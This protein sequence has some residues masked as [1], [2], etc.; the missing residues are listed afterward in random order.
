MRLQN[1]KNAI[2]GRP[3]SNNQLAR[4]KLNVLWGLPVLASDAVSSVAYA[5]EEIMI[6]LVAGVA[7]GLN[8][9][10]YAPFVAIPIIVLLVTLV[11]SY[12]QIINHYPNGGG[13]Y[14]V[15]SDNFGKKAGLLAGTA[16]IVDYIM[17]VAVSVSA[18]TQA[19]IAAFGFMAPYRTPFSI[20][21]I[22]LVSVLNLRGIRESSRIFG[23]PTYIFIFSMGLMIVVGF[24]R[25]ITG[26]LTPIDPA[27]YANTVHSVSNDIF[28][29]IYL[30]AFASGC[31]A[32]TGVEAVSNAI[33]N[34][35][36]PAQKRAKRVL[37]LLGITIVFIMSG[38]TT[39][40]SFVRVA[41]LPDVTITA[42]IGAVVFGRS[43]M[44]YI[45][46]FST[47]L[48]LLLATNTAYND[49]PIVLSILAKDGF[50]PRQFAQRGAKLS[51]SNGILFLMVVSCTLL[52][53]FD[54]DTH[55]LIPF[56]AVGVFISFTMS[57]TGM[58]VK[59]TRLKEKGWHGK[60]LI[61]LLG[62]IITL[63]GLAVVFYFKFLDGAWAL[64]IV[65]PGL[66][67]IMLQIKKHYDKVAKQLEVDPAVA[68]EIR[69]K[70]P[71]EANPPCVILFRSLNKAS[72]KTLNY[73]RTISNNLTALHISTEEPSAARVREIQAALGDDIKLEVV[74]APFRDLIPPLD[75]Y[76][77]KKEE[78]LKEHQKL[79]VI[80]TKYVDNNL[81]N[82][83]LH[84]QTAYFIENHLKQ[85]RKV[86]TVIVPYIYEK[87]EKSE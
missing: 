21:C 70:P 46:Q 64:L 51:F 17:T 2:L 50:M 78:T 10:Q 8:A 27:V 26:T 86:V 4:E 56:Y 63:V 87:D 65:I 58:V 59:W 83:L 47:S 41:P 23:V 32:L 79:T 54:S 15:S 85:F 12:S 72:I 7:I 16:L 20:A 80:M 13:S 1:I 35:R 49:L 74:I 11:V 67:F 22:V 61:N 38:T 29:L 53:I 30:K 82:R 6:A 18:S 66:I 42:Q 71:Y 76:I 44:F 55:R 62:A 48:I 33:P 5:M 45:L 3:L 77:S 68:D 19:I 28:I 57:Q 69:H 40:A 81:L 52:I 25:Q 73:A 36:P 24:F 37:L 14:L 9:Y 60:I 75:D 31:S 34:F 39:L 84:N 43:F